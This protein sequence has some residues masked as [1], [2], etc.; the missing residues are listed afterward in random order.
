M[1]VCPAVHTR[2]ASGRRSH[3]NDRVASDISLG[4]QFVCVSNHRFTS[5]IEFALDVGGHAA[6]TEVERGYIRSLIAFQQQGF[7]GIG[8]DLADQFPTIAEKKFWAGVFFDV[9]RLVFL[10]KLGNQ[11]VTSWQA[12]LIG[13]AY[14]VA[15][16]L[17]RAVQLE[18]LAWH[19][20]TGDAAEAAAWRSRVRF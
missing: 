19:P 6:R 20:D 13:D 15:R 10:R 7:P 2:F 5:L 14:I 12:T 18:E 9:A 8:L 1:N 11:K 16:M 17:T 3:D 4:D